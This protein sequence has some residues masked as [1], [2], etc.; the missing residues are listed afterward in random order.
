M[1]LLGAVLLFIAAVVADAAL[2]RLRLPINGVMRFIFVG[3]IAGTAL[4]GILLRIE[5]ATPSVL[6]ALLVYAFACELYI[7]VFTTSLASIGANILIALSKHPR[8]GV[9][10]AAICESRTMVSAR[11]NRLVVAG[12]MQANAAPLTLTIKGKKLVRTISAVRE[13][14]RHKNR[15]RDDARTTV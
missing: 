8:D 7:F 1:S 15:G 12:L 6:A 13:F 11:L 3:V 10:A 5:G 14:F 4:T 9:E 2:A